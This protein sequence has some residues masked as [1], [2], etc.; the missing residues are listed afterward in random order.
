M[1]ENQEQNLKTNSQISVV[2]FNIAVWH[3]MSHMMKTSNHILLAFFFL[4]FK[5]RCA[6]TMCL[7]RYLVIICFQ[8]N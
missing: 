8:F 1:G 2:F 6:K 7:Q 5:P 3:C 4:P